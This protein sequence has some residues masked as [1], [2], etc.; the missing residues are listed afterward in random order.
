MRHTVIIA[1]IGECFNG[2][3]NIA[4]RLICEA[5]RAG[6]DLVKFQTLD[7]EKINDND[8]ERDWFK[9]IA[10]DQDK[11]NYLIECAS[12]EN[13]GILFSPAN[14]KTAQWLLDAGLSSVKIASTLVT[15]KGLLQFVNESFPRVFLST[16]MC[17][18]DEVNDLVLSLNM[19]SELFIMHCVS[20]YPTGPLLEQRGLK[21]LAPEDVRLNMMR[22]LQ[23]LYPQHRVGYSDHT[24]DILAP[25]AAVAM[26]AQVIEKHITLDRKSPM[27]NYFAGREYLGTDH[28]LSIEPEELQEMVRQIREVEKM[29]GP[30]RWERSDG[31]KILREFLRF[32]FKSASP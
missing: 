16:G 26:G 1:E 22:I 10:L 19:V 15:D 13:I 32:R 21:A 20:E 6:C 7:R 28:V 18:L 25:V 4:N 17:S 12:H 31:E 8:P 3:L 2:D 27:E 14:R 29:Q 5:K 30:W 24:A 9:K 23:Q 11:I